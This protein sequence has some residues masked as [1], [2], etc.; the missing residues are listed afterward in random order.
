M[1]L[2]DHTDRAFAVVLAFYRLDKEKDTSKAMKLIRGQ[3]MN[4]Q[5]Y[6]G[7][8]LV[9]VMEGIDPERSDPIP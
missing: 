8:K 1:P 2:P 4:L 9:T 6:D 5:G 7:K 3:I